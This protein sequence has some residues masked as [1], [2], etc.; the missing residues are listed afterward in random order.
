MEQCV[1]PLRCGLVPAPVLGLAECAPL[2][3]PAMVVSTGH[4]C[5][6]IRI[7]TTSRSPFVGALARNRAEFS[8]VQ[9]RASSSKCFARQWSFCG[10]SDPISIVGN[11]RAK[12]LAEAFSIRESRTVYLTRLYVCQ[13][14]LEEGKRIELSPRQRWPRVQTSFGPCPLPSG[15][16]CRSILIRPLRAPVLFGTPPRSRTLHAKFRRLCWA[17]GP[18]DKR[19]LRIVHGIMPI[20][21]PVLG[22]TW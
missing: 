8:G 9:S 7:V 14:N 22:R 16:C 15:I 6:L 17:S 21:P 12:P 1:P 10:V 18:R 4:C 2:G 13:V 19:P 11:D 3:F 20:R 5:L